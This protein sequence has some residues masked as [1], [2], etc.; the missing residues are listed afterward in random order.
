MLTTVL[1]PG[2]VAVESIRDLTVYYAMYMYY[3][4]IILVDS[5]TYLLLVLICI[6]KCSSRGVSAQSGTSPCVRSYTIDLSKAWYMSF[7]EF[8]VRN[9]GT[10]TSKNSLCCELITTE[11]LVCQHPSI[12]RPLFG[13]HSLLSFMVSV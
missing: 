6:L 1:V 7:V 4:T 5:Y 12:F 10:C 11:L 2:T 8:H 9:S 13:M 3:S